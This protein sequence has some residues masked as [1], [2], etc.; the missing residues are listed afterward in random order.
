MRVRIT[1]AAS[2]DLLRIGDYIELDNPLR[3]ESFILELLDHCRSLAQHAERYPIATHWRGRDFRR[4]PHGSYLIIYS[5]VDGVVE[6]NH[7]A[8]SA[9]HYMRLLFPDA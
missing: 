6:I 9:R 4:C 2:E 3:A 5:I 7:I 8:H 1:R